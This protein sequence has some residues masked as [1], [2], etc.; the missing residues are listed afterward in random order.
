MTA[1]ARNLERIIR[2]LAAHP[3]A[4][5]KDFSRA[6]FEAVQPVTPSLIRYT[7]ATDYDRLARRD[8]R[9]A[10]DII[11][12]KDGPFAAP[13]GNGR[14]VRLLW[15]TPKADARVVACLIHASS[16]K[17]LEQCLAAAAAM[18]DRERAALIDTALRHMEAYDPALREFEHADLR[19]ELTVSASCFAQLK[20]HRM[21]T[22]TVQDYDPTLGVTVP[23]SLREVGM[24][25]AFLEL[26]ART[27]GVCRRIADACPR[28][29]AYLLTNAHRRRVALKVN[30]RELYHISRL[31]ADR[32]AQWD[33]RRVAEEMIA[34][35]RAVMPLTLELA[36]GKDG[37]ATCKQGNGGASSPPHSH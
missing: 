30:A 3:L 8:L 36:C 25:E 14:D 27:D 7:E 34:Q 11:G 28:A 18:N 32:H 16:L 23:P 24:D 35:A 1:N 4:E 21:A 17:P 6:L 2:R 29:A 20:R 12:K 33:I 15:A 10:V 22:L 9:E 26:V 37:F 31:R 13:A 5:A 19:Y